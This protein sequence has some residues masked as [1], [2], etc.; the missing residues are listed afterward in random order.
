MAKFQA[1]EDVS[2]LDEAALSEAVEAALAAFSE[3]ADIDDAELSDDQVEEMEAIAAFAE[4]ASAERANR[5][6]AAAERAAHLASLRQSMAGQSR[7][8]DDPED[9]AMD[10]EDADEPAETPGELPDAEDIAEEQE[11]GPEGDTSAPIDPAKDPK[12][13]KASVNRSVASRAAQSATRQ[14]APARPQAKLVAASNVPNFA[15]GQQFSDLH[16][17][18]PVLMN[19]LR[20]LP[21]SGKGLTRNSALV[22]Q[23]PETKLSQAN[24]LGRDSE[25]L[26]AASQESR[27]TGGS[28]VA[29]GGWGAPSEIVM[30]FCKQE[31]TDGLLTIPEVTVTRGGLNYTKGP[32]FAD[33]IGATSGFWDMTEAVAEAGTE[34]KTSL[35]PTVPDFED[36]RLDAVGT[37]IEAGLLLRSG[38]P[39][40]IDRYSDLA[41][42]VHAYKM[43]AK[44]I[45]EIQAFTGAAINVPNGFGNAIDV[46]NILEVVA[47]G[48]RQRYAL[49]LEAT[50]E[51][52]LPE[53][54]QSVIR[55]DLA[56]RT[57]VD[58]A[59]AITD[60]QIDSY[61]A[62][63][64][65]KV[66][67][68]RGYQ[69]LDVTT[70]GIATAYPA[71][72]EAIVY[73]AGT[74]V[75]GT[76]DVISLDTIYDSTNLKKN[77]YVHLFVEQ[78]TVV[79]NPCGEGRRI[80]IPLAAN[81]RTAAANYAGNL[82]VAGV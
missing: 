40:L 32:T 77:D 4:T 67:W 22:I 8:G 1:P 62:A 43:S 59:L 19:R 10:P 79:T 82:F 55:A 64:G 52:L 34:L 41:L 47:L 46:L 49:A 81:G 6:T 24:Y 65:L 16:E 70:A 61:F 44:T 54:V 29:A 56:N 63:R 75:R 17:A 76:S 51:V 58:N 48:E 9:E 68:L 23:L 35:R 3:F 57:G 71:T 20:S 12:Q 25:L 26:L 69:N 72:V 31:T 21:T 33:V 45:A 78:G 74:Y 2:A 80:T 60:Q 42:V 7:N 50:L 18:G 11:E 53:W 37:M 15:A 30:D 39:E 13:K 28:L 66:Q 14:Q 36:A 73:P 5:E 38:W 27:L